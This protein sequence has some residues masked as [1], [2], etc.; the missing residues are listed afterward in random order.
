M[1]R[2]LSWNI[3]CGRGVDG[4]V[5]LHRIAGTIRAAGETDLVCLQEVARRMP[6]LDGGAGADQAAELAALLPAYE[7]VF[8]P[9]LDLADGRGGRRRFGNLVLSRRPV[10]QVFR[11]QLPQPADPGALHMPR[12]A[13]EVV[14]ETS[15]GPLR[16]ITTH[17]EYHS[18]LQRLAQAGRL[19]ALQREAAENA[20][21]PPSRPASGPYADRPRPARCVLCGDLNSLPGD[22]VMRRLLAPFPAA[23]PKFLDAWRVAHGG[24]P[25]APTCGIFDREQWPEGPHCRDFFLITADLAGAVAGFTVDGETDASDHQP[26]LLELRA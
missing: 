5:D 12:Q 20:L 6:E 23:I 24:R 17:L 21:H 18:E 1:I 13:T 3:Q 10:L 8:G 16:V 15:L 19:R 11:H 2:L 25:H 22:R 9:A 26:L 7:P 4:S 14:V